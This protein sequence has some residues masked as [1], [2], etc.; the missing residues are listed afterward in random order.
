MNTLQQIRSGELTGAKHVKLSCALKEFPRELFDLA[1]SLEI[2]DLSVNQLSSLP[3]DFHRFTK[4]K[5]LFCSEN[6]F[7]ELPEV[8]GQCKALEMIGFKSNQIHTIS[9]QA[10]PTQ[11]RWLILTNNKIKQLP[12]SIGKCHRL[13]KVAL[14]GN[15]L[16]ELPIE[17]AG[18]HNLELL[19]ISANQ[20][21]TLPHWLLHLPKLSWLAFSGNIFN[22]NHAEPKPL[23]EIMWEEFTLEEQL[24]E[25][26]SG[27]IYKALWPSNE[28]HKEVAIKVF[29]GEVTS[30]GFPEDEMQATIAAGPH[31]NLVTLLGCISDHPHQKMGL[32]MELIPPS[33]K[34]L[35]LPPSF[36]SCTRDTFKEGTCFTAEQILKIVTQVADAANQL[37]LRGLMHGDLY[38]HNILIDSNDHILMGDFGAACFYDLNSESAL[39][40]ERMEVRAFGCLL[41]DLLLHINKSESNNATVL[42]VKELR[43]RCWKDT[44]D[45]RP[46]F[47]EVC[48]ILIKG[49]AN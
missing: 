2:L 6:L 18:C 30:D 28:H 27:N 8:L 35:G 16:A 20:L 4:L 17:M 5:I 44:T 15:L 33:Y 49:A 7:T 23:Q 11:T 43:D 34:N 26:A 42:A 40:V 48:H 24:G 45:E 10:L 29:K 22:A 46:L 12:T 38:A 19:R 25:G 9:E 1:E 37:H 36:S 47:S 13:Q 41:D 39:N 21:N 32:V 14:A 3:E 31:P